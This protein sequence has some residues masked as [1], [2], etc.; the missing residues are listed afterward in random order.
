M[1]QHGAADLVIAAPTGRG[2]TV[3]RIIVRNVRRSLVGGETNEIQA[4]L[5]LADSREV[6]LNEQLGFD[7]QSLT[8]LAQAV[9]LGNI[10]PQAADAVGAAAYRVGERAQ[11]A[12]HAD[13][14]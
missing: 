1:I 3:D 14:G 2:H 11:I 9:H 10:R 4:A 8:R 13:P 7:G 5:A 12:G 6:A